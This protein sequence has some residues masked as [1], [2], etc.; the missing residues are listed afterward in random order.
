MNLLFQHY[1]EEPISSS[2]IQIA[3]LLV[4]QFKGK[5]IFNVNDEL[6]DTNVFNMTEVQYEES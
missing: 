5:S 4:L 3:V 6:K 2:F 1:V